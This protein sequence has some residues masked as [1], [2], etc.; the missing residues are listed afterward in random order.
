MFLGADDPL[1]LSYTAPSPSASYCSL[2]ASPSTG[3]GSCPLPVDRE[4]HAVSHTAR[5]ANLYELLY[6]GLRLS[7]QIPL[8]LIMVANKALDSADVFF[9]EVLGSNARINLSGGQD[10]LT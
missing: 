7:P 3:I 6:A 8:H 10:F 4:I 5:A 9:A 1:F 2:G